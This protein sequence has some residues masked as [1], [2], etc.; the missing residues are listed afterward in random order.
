MLPHFN[1]GLILWGH[2]NTRLHKLQKRAIRTITNLIYNSHT[3]PICK[4]LNI[5]KLPDLY[6]LE[7]YK[8]NY[9]I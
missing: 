8:L 3:E 2:D 4:L 9:K 7:L 1:Y 5:I 6:K